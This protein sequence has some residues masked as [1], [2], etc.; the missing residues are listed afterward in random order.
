LPRYHLDNNRLISTLFLDYFHFTPILTGGQTA[1]PQINTA[2]R[3]IVWCIDILRSS[4]DSTMPYRW[5][6]TYPM[7]W[8]PS[9]ASST[10]PNARRW[11]KGWPT[12]SDDNTWWNVITAVTKTRAVCFTHS[13]F[14]KY[15]H[16]PRFQSSG[17]L[18]YSFLQI[19]YHE[20]K[21]F[22][23]TLPL[24]VY[25]VLKIFGSTIEDD[26]SIQCIM[27]K[28]FNWEILLR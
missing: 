18:I 22:K 12:E 23:I 4:D 28:F 2:I 27:F 19:N 7:T 15:D 8:S 21:V 13:D 9:F 25:S 11:D 16:G 10:R 26:K 1:T 3:T 14:G 6:A 24:Q 20:I 17:D 5:N